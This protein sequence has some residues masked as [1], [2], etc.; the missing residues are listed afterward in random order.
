MFDDNIEAIYA[1]QAHAFIRER[2][3]MK[4]GQCNANLREKC[5]ANLRENFERFYTKN[6]TEP[7]G[8]LYSLNSGAHFQVESEKLSQEV[9]ARDVFRRI[10]EYSGENSESG[11]FE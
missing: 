6:T 2:F 9:R 1:S 11:K 4:T 5:N 10:R 3:S 7:R 8:A